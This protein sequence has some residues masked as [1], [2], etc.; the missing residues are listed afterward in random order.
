MPNILYKI[1]IFIKFNK[2]LRIKLN[3]L[4]VF[5]QYILNK[6]IVVILIKNPKKP[7]VPKSIARRKEVIIKQADA[8]Y[9]PKET[10][11]ALIAHL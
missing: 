3:T 4:F 2:K 11:I 7:A 1:N 9:G 8:K 6:S 5:L 10:N